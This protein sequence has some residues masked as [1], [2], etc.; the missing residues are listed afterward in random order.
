MTTRVIKTQSDIE[1]LARL[2]GS[3]QLPVTVTIT[4]GANRTDAQNRLIQ[5]WNQEITDQ[6]GDSPFE[7]VRAENKLRFGV[8]ILRRDHED[9]R[10][11]YDEAIRPMP[12][13]TKIR[14]FVMIDPPITRRMTTKQ[15]S[16]YVD[17]LS[18]HYRQSGFQ[19]THPDD[20]KYG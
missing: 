4:A 13:E 17:T 14:L 18:L 5:K 20:R 6:R 3:R 1:G 8:P 12:Y 16:E 2:L 19:L 10:A 11:W 15:L 7:D 9:F